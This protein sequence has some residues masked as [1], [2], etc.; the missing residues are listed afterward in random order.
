MIVTPT[1][2]T[3]SLWLWLCVIQRELVLVSAEQHVESY[4]I[5]SLVLLA[6]FAMF[7]ILLVVLHCYLR[8]QK[9]KEDQMRH[10]LSHCDSNVVWGRDKQVHLE[11]L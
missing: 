8:R 11:N 3:S 6:S 7:A 2:H 1:Y 5:G 4:R 10:D 9:M